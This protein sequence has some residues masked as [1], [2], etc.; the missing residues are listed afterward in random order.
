MGN[1]KLL[2]T[3]FLVTQLGLSM[4]AP[5]ALGTFF[6]IVIDRKLGTNWVVVFL[7]LVGAC[8][9]F[10]NSWKL[11][12]RHM[13]KDDPVY[14]PARRVEPHLSPAEREFREWKERKAAEGEST[15]R[16]DEKS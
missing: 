10:R 11:L 13:P 16:T 7:M 8:A 4:L 6:G 9:G 2:Q 5:I 3:L 1:K 14:V 15:A 12:K